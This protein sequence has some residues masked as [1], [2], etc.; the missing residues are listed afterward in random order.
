MPSST[1]TTTTAAFDAD[2]AAF[3]HECSG[4]EFHQEPQE[5]VQVVNLL[6]VPRSTQPPPRSGT[7]IRSV[8]VELVAALCS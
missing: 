2:R 7:G 1:T 4:D 6:Y 3:L 5:S 8:T